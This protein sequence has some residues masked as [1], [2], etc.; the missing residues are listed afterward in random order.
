MVD[1]IGRGRFRLG[2][3]F[4]VLATGIAWMMA[5]VAVWQALTGTEWG[6]ATHLVRPVAFGG[7]ATLFA[8]L[9]WRGAE[10][11]WGR[12][13]GA[14]AMWVSIIA[15]AFLAFA[16]MALMIRYPVGGGQY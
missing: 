5:A 1:R 10:T 4:A 12:R 14:I 15:V 7:V 11:P 3:R 6:A 9:W 8:V 13:S 2:T 16:G